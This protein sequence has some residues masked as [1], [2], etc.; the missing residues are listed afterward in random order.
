[1]NLHAYGGVGGTSM[2]A[3]ADSTCVQIFRAACV[4]PPIPLQYGRSYATRYAA[5]KIWTQLTSAVYVSGDLSSI[6]KLIYSCKRGSCLP[7]KS[8]VVGS[9][10]LDYTLVPKVSIELGR[11]AYV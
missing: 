11:V 7:K 3:T 10:Q 9:Y 6:E 2:L 8:V 1:M 5:R 4:G